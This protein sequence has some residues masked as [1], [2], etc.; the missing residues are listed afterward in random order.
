M[1]SSKMCHLSSKKMERNLNRQKTT[2]E[3]FL[4]NTHFLDIMLRTVKPSPI[5]PR[6][7]RTIYELENPC[8]GRLGRKCDFGTSG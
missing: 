7:E 6:E 8:F 1:V 3:K 4:K 2:G 5:Y